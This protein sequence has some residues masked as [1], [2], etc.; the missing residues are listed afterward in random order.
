[1]K[2]FVAI[3]HGKP[4]SAG[5]ADELLRPLSEE[6]KAKT[7]LIVGKLQEL[8]ISPRM[9]YTSP[10]IRAEQTARIFADEFGVV[11]ELEKALGYELDGEVL[12]NHLRKAPDDAVLFYVGHAPKL[13]DFVDL[14][15]GEKALTE[16]LSKGSAA[17]IRFEDEV[18]A[19]QG[20]LV[21]YLNT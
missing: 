11:V 20:H 14:L 9:I 12:L 7:H 16:G 3:R 17:V 10:I 19:G 1:M 6:G 13:G 5:Y 15:V 4:E 21:S 8:E 18:V 2:T